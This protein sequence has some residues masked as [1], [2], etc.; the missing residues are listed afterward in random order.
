MFGTEEHAL[1]SPRNGFILHKSI[2]GQFDIGNVT[3][4]PHGSV[5]QVPTEWKLIVLYPGI[6]KHEVYQDPRTNEITTW[7]V[8]CMLLDFGNFQLIL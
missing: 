4:V 3:I 5:D 2:E 6:L 7:R 1:E 8:S